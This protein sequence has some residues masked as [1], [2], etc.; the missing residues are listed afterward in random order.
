MD[1]ICHEQSASTIARQAASGWV[2]SPKVGSASTASAGTGRWTDS[3]PNDSCASVT[4][5]SKLVLPPP[6]KGSVAPGFNGSSH[7]RPTGG[8]DPLQPFKPRRTLT[9]GHP[10]GLELCRFGAPA[11]VM[12]FTNAFRYRIAAVIPWGEVLRG[13]VKPA[14]PRRAC[15]PDQLALSEVPR[16]RS[17]WR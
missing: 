5:P 10:R 13:L 16:L 7:A 11:G 14:R 1:A 8:T 12:T 17:D 3:Q 4:G 15:D 9:G 6:T 2:L